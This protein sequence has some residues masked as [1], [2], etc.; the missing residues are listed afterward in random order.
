MP[1]GRSA[2]SNA[3]SASVTAVPT[4][5]PPAS[6]SVAVASST[7]RPELSAVTVPTSRARCGSSRLRST[8]MPTSNHTLDADGWWPALAAVSV[9]APSGTP[10][11]R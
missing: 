10:T 1:A 8:V 4:T 3:P 5:T 9:Y 6:T 11:S 2:K 7:G